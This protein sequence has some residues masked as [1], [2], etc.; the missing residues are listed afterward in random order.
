MFKYLLILGLILFSSQALQG[1]FELT[2]NNFASEVHGNPEE[3]TFWI[4]LFAAD[5]VRYP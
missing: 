5:W 2:D 3:P 1:V 4:V